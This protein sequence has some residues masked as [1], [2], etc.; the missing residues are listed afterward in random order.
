MRNF[1]IF[2]SQ[3][4]KKGYML[5]EELIL[6]VSEHRILGASFHV[7]SAQRTDEGTWLLL[8]APDAKQEEERGTPAEKVRLIKLVDEVSD[9]ALMKAYSRQ[10]STLAFLKEM[11]QETLERFVRPRI[12]L[13]N[14]RIVELAQQTDIPVFWRE[15]ISVK[16]FYEDYRVRIVPPAAECLFHFVKDEKGLRY[17]ISLTC[18]GREISLRKKPG[19][20][21]SEKPCIV[22]A[23]REILCV[24]NIEAKKLIPFFGK[25]HID[26]PA[27]TE[28][29]YL[30]NFVFK[31][32][33]VYE[34]KIQGIPVREIKPER[35]AFLSLERD[36]RQEMVCILTFRYNDS[37][38]IYPGNTRKKTVEMEESAGGLPAIRWFKR[39]MEWETKLIRHLQEE[40]LR[41]EGDSHFYP[42]AGNK[43][44][45]RLIEWM[46]QRESD[47]LQDF[48]LEYNLERPYFIRPVCVNCDFK[49][50]TDWFEINIEV[51]I[52]AY[53]L[54]FAC[55][56]KHI[57]EGNNEYVLPDGTV[58]ILP[59]EWFEKYQDI[60]RFSEEM[61]GS[62][63]LKKMYTPLL[64]HTLNKQLTDEKQKIIDEILQI[65]IV[66]PQLPEQASLLLRPYQKE[67]FYWLEH[68]YKNGFGGC[69]ADDMG[70][71]KTLQ[72]ITLLQ[73]IYAEDKQNSLPPALVVAPTSLLHNWKNELARFAPELR[74]YLHAGDKR[75]KNEEAAKMFSASQVVVAS[76]G[77]M[78]KDVEFLKEYTFQMIVLDESQYIKNASSLA[79]QAAVQLVGPHKLALTGTPLE[80]SLDDLW[81]QF[82]F[83]NKGLL[84]DLQSF[85]RDFVLPI[86]R[87]KN[88]EREGLLK[89]LIGPFLLRR[90][91]EEV[92][93]ELPPLIQE[94]IYCD[95][96][97]EQQAI[98][99]AEKNRI[100][101]LLL[102]IREDPKPARKHFVALQ[103][104]NKL[105]QLA[106]HPKLVEADYSED[107]GKF[108]QV[109]LSF[110][111]LKASNHKVLV[112]SSY[113]RYLN[114]LAERFDSEGWKYAM[115]TGE[116]QKREEEIKRFT[117]QTDVHCFF[118]SLKAGSTGLNLTA[119]D[120]VFI[121]DPWWNPATEMQALSRAHRIGQE[122]NVI[123]CRFISTGTVEE[124]IMR[125]QETKTTLYETFINENNPLSQFAWAEIEDLLENL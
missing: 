29:M 57:L 72:T 44:P 120:Y 53:T 3:N 35:K 118:I 125:L 7:Y 13:A 66:C 23:G 69:L 45:F 48:I 64:D 88:E 62:L 74:V 17:F 61:D 116:T 102:E 18:E 8:G 110:E 108:E 1:L 65:P 26:V 117:D 105:R 41:Q 113:V 75:L 68:L 58:F 122:K 119:A 28:A 73:Y 59:C 16:T 101:N 24:E 76:Y 63:R 54:P 11:K 114:L 123:A 78:R 124:K 103:G 85:R 30:K 36:F 92:A 34:V 33:Q 27:Q 4:I 37:P 104:L 107:A 40:G 49:A 86:A 99:E 46:N 5:N 84:G 50:E 39:D 14:R 15:E 31:T 22:L 79:Y 81:A 97:E 25:N 112:F 38:R 115:L 42:A 9:Q 60:L 87:E 55:F 12:E 56:R 96:T 51:V 93:P 10:K 6:I 95:M 32:M 52:G 20:I 71:G 70:L 21:L 106:N 111:T 47:A 19:L 121:L 83:I 109:L 80:N 67:G 43:E 94:V 89:R 77:V 90:T 82:N 2:V 98:Y 100:R 91:K